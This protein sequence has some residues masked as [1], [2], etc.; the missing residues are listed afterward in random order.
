MEALSG[1][2]RKLNFPATT[3][4]SS[5]KVDVTSKEYIEEE[6]RIS[7]EIE[8]DLKGYDCPKCKN[9]G[10]IYEPR[11][12]EM[13]DYWNTVA[14]RCDCMPIREE[15][16]RLEKSGLEALK[17]KTFDNYNYYEQWQRQIWT[18]A[19]AYANN[20]EGWFYIGGQPGCGKTHICTAIVNR[21][22]KNGKAARYMLW[23]DETTELKQHINDSEVY[24]SLIKPLKNADVLYIDDFF[25]KGQ[26][27]P[28][29]AADVDVT[30]KI[31]NFRYI[32]KLPTIIS[33]EKSVAQIIRI[34]EAL[35]SR[36]AEMTKG[37]ELYIAPD[38]KKNYRLRRK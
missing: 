22:I 21:L 26:N 32:K 11:F 23:D 12:S 24:E 18:E 3:G 15:L 5:S 7:N 34:D 31:I 8:G 16:I 10:V 30:F 1:V 17:D 38:I 6:C 2:L 25:K 19:Q 28:V 27:A 35:G 14:V 20:P 37:K 36:I 4:G 29:T 33:A 13:Y 9:K